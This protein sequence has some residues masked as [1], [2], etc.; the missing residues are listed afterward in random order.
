M[1]DF[2][3]SPEMLLGKPTIHI[4]LNLIIQKVEGDKVVGVFQTS[5]G[6][7]LVH[8]SNK[9]HQLV[10][11]D[12]FIRPQLVFE[13]NEFRGSGMSH[14]LTQGFIEQEKWVEG[15]LLFKR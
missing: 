7:P 1:L 10:I 3:L 12:A 6:T 5:Y 9:T 15:G 13:S 11:A 8:G 14:L 2:G 4:P